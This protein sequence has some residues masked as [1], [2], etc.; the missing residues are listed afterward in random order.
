MAKNI[1]GTIAFFA[2]FAIIFN[3]FNSAALWE[4]GVKTGFE[5][6]DVASKQIYKREYRNKYDVVFIGNSHAYC[7]FYPK[8]LWQQH[9]IA[10]HVFASSGQEL[11]VSEL[12]VKETTKNQQPKAIVVEVI[13]ASMNNGFVLELNNE[14]SMLNSYSMLP[15]SVDKLQ[16]LFF[17]FEEESLVDKLYPLFPIVTFHENWKYSDYDNFNA[18][19]F[20]KYQYNNG[21]V[22]HDIVCEGLQAP[23]NLPENSA[24]F[25]EKSKQSLLNIIDICKENDIE[26]IFTVAPYVISEESQQVMNSVEEIAMANDIPFINYNN[27]Y[28]EIGIDFSNDFKDEGHLNIYGMEKVSTHFGNYLKDNLDIPDRRG[29]EKYNYYDLADERELIQTLS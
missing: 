9:G 5:S 29:D 22:L 19:D 12:Y 3:Y 20:E 24:D 14:F 7:T 8:I 26:L 10:S 4:N 21:A 16:T 23:Q 13:S 28:D 18:I 6:T 15:P 2:V 25:S 1:I 11:Y 17:A 27:M